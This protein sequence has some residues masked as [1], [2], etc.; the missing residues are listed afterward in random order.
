MGYNSDVDE[1]FQHQA[2]NVIEKYVLTLVYVQTHQYW[3]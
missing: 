2:K 3:L 1:C